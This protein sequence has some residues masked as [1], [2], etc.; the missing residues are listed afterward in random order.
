[1]AKITLVG[2]ARGSGSRALSWVARFMDLPQAPLWAWPEVARVRS[3]TQTT[4]ESSAGGKAD[5]GRASPLARGEWLREG[6]E[7]KYLYFM[8]DNFGE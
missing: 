6:V 1:M 7:V 3:G 8:G 5:N 2:L 4:E